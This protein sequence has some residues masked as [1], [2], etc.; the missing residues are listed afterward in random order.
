MGL[1]MYRVGLTSNFELL[2]ACCNYIIQYNDLSRRLPC[3]GLRL[4]ELLLERAHAP[5]A[6]RDASCKKSKFADLETTISHA[7]E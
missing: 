5:A 6:A 4:N 1:L 2:R 7:E 3:E